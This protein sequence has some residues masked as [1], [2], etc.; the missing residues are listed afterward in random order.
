MT[1]FKDEMSLKIPAYLRGDLSDAEMKEIESYAAKNAEFSADIEFQK[2]LK[3][4]IKDSHDGFVPGEMGW[5]RLSK[6][7]KAESSDLSS[8]DQND[9]RAAND[10][11]NNKSKAL[12]FWR[13]AA[14]I[15]AVAVIGQAGAIGFI[16]SGDKSEPQYVTVSELARGDNT[17]KI[18]FNKSV[19]IGELTKEMSDLGGVIISGPSALGLYAISFET[20]KTCLEAV[21]VLETNTAMVETISRCN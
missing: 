3:S 11:S 10:T 17:V 2:Q 14:A 13:Y 7:M 20:S 4:A 1:S 15:L 21:E 16:S 5:A 6:A 8:S 9:K 18:A 19:T 12:N